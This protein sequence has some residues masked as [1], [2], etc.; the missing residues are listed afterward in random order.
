VARRLRH[1]QLEARDERLL[2]ARVLERELQ[3]LERHHAGHRG[4]QRRRLTMSEFFRYRFP[5]IDL[6]SK[7]I[8]IKPVGN[9][10]FKKKTFIKKTCN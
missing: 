9:F 10:A 6:N 5:A 2:E 8:L 3:L 4:H 1:E 7:A